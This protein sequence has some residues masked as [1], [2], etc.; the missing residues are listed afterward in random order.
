MC[1]LL[2]FSPVCTENRQSLQLKWMLSFV[3]S[4]CPPKKKK[5]WRQ[6]K[7]SSWFCFFLFFLSPV[8]EERCRL[9]WFC[10]RVYSRLQNHS[11]L[12]WKKRVKSTWKK[13]SREHL[14]WWLVLFRF[15]RDGEMKSLPSGGDC[16][17]DYFQLRWMGVREVGVISILHGTQ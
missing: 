10:S 6:K 1:S 17:L 8:L 7:L 11:L 5:K 12:S 14:K 9:C 15:R 4:S 2:H 3:E 16:D 13:Q